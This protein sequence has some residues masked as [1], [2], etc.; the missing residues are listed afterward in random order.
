M[1][2]EQPPDMS[3]PGDESYISCTEQQLPSD[4]DVLAACE[5]LIASQEESLNM[6][7]NAFCTPGGKF[8]KQDGQKVNKEKKGKG[9]PLCLDSW[10]RYQRICLPIIFA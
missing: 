5:N 9:Y 1:A 3:S 2:E 8:R 7:K 4:L 6:N 10:I